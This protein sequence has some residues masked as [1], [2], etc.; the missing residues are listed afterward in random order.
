MH[1]T[2]PLM[3]PPFR[4]GKTNNPDQLLHV[5]GRNFAMLSFD[6]LFTHLDA[7]FH[8]HQGLAPVEF[9]GDYGAGEK[10]FECKRFYMKK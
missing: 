2:S 7:V 9:I 10:A 4:S 3:T 8:R 6:K 1:S 5:S